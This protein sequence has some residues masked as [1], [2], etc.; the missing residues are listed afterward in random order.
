[1]HFSPSPHPAKSRVDPQTRSA[2][3]LGRLYEDLHPAVLAFMATRA[4]NDPEDLAADVFVAVAE[5]LARFEGD[6]RSFRSW[7]F[8]IAYRSVGNDRRRMGRRRTTPIT[9]DHLERWVSPDS[10]ED[11][12]LTAMGTTHS[13][14]VLAN[15]PTAHRPRR[16]P[17]RTPP[18]LSAARPVRVTHMRTS[19]LPAPIPTPRRRARTAPPAIGRR[20]Q[21]HLLGLAAG[22]TPEEFAWSERQPHRL[23]D[24]ARVRV[25]SPRRARIDP[26]SAV[27][28]PHP[29]SGDINSPAP[30]S[31]AVAVPSPS[32]CKTYTWGEGGRLRDTQERR[33]TE[34]GP[35]TG[36]GQGQRRR[37]R[38]GSGGGDEHA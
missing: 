38:S 17:C 11:D 34:K 30:P 18:A 7:V 4:H 32:W 23:S 19:R 35:Q 13:L 16:P 27:G 24:H 15:L 26:S 14:S 20:P 29:R 22:E 31:N 3:A 8:T 37:R 1:M 5:G 10:A 36:R 9:P 33:G 6:E 25:A 2:E 21:Q 28:R 12:A